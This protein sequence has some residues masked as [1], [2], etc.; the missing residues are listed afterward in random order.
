MTLRLS[1]REETDASPDQTGRRVVRNCMRAKD[2][3]PDKATDD[4]QPDPHWLLRGRIAHARLTG[5][6]A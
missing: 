5:G 2:S 3:R 4:D 1:W 6:D